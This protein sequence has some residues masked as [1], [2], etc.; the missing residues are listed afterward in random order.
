MGIFYLSRFKNGMF[1][2][3]KKKMSAMHC[4]KQGISQSCLLERIKTLE[5]P[6][7][8]YKVALLL[9]SEPPLNNSVTDMMAYQLNQFQG[10]KVFINRV[11]LCNAF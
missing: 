5:E 4:V 10:N 11:V 3:K 6:Q 2:L 9:Y 1:G 8:Q 7:R